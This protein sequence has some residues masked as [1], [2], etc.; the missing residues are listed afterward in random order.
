MSACDQLTFD[1]VTQPQWDCIKKTVQQ[2]TGIIITSDSG[3]AS[4]RGFTVAWNYNTQTLGLTLHVTNK[5]FVISC[6]T[7]NSI[8]EGVVSGCPQ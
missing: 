8:I 6:E 2:K 4:E 7:I 3:S 1:G 5:P